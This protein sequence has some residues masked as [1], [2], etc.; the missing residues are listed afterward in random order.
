M[1]IRIVC[2][3]NTR[4]PD[5][6]RSLAPFQSLKMPVPRQ[7][8]FPCWQGCWQD[9]DCETFHG[10]YLVIAVEIYES[11][12]HVLFVRFSNP[13]LWISSRSR[14]NAALSSLVVKC[15]RLRT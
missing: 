14:S 13:I 10:S 9:F 7:H 2:L 12:P 5:R 1:L 8:A 4:S 3:K 6:P 15:I 11:D